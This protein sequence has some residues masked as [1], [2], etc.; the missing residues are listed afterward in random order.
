[1]CSHYETRSASSRALA[2]AIVTASLVLSMALVLAACGEISF[3]AGQHL[4]RGAAFEAQGDFGAASIE[5]RN[6]LQQDPGNAEAR[7][8]LGMLLLGIRDGSGAEAEL[9]RAQD[10]GWDPGELILPLA[11][12]MWLQGEHEDVLAATQQTDALPDALVPESLALRGLAKLISGDTAGAREDFEQA[13]AIA[14]RQ[15]DALMGMA[16]LEASQGEIQR[17]REWL[18]ELLAADPGAD[19]AWEFLGD[20]EEHAGDAE[21]ALAA[22]DRAVEL[23]PQPLSPLLK[24][25]L[26]RV[27]LQDL[28]GA[29]ADAATLERR[30]DA[31]PGASYAQ[32][33]IKFHEQSYAEA[34]TFFEESLVRHTDYPPALL[35]LGSTHLQL[36]NAQQAEQLLRRY[37][38]LVPDSVPAIEQLVRLHA[39]RTEPNEARRLLRDLTGGSNGAHPRLKALES[40]LALASGD[41]EQGLALLN[42]LAAA[43]PDAAQWHELRGMEL[44]RQGDRDGGMTALRQ[45]AAVDEQARRAD[46]IIIM[47]ELDAGNYESA[48]A[49]ARSLQEK[50]PDR[51]EPWN[52]IG[53]AL[54]GLGR[55]EDAREA[56]RQGVAVE[57]SHVATGMNLGNLELVLGNPVGADEAFRT[58]QHHHPGHAPSAQ[59]LA[60]LALQAQ[61]FDAAILW[62]REATQAQPEAIVP[63]LL[64]A[65]IQVHQ[66]Q[67]AEAAQTLEQ[68][69]EHH[70][71]DRDVPYALSEVY[72]EAGRVEDALRVLEHALADAPDDLDFTLA[73]AQVQLRAGNLTAHEQALRKALAL[74]PQHF[75]ARVALARTLTQREAWGELEPHLRELRDQHAD[76]AEVQA[77]IGQAALAQGDAVEAATAYARAVAAHPGE[78]SWVVGLATAQWQANAREQSQTTLRGWLEANPDDLATW[79]MLAG[80]QLGLDQSE[81]ALASYQQILARNPDDPIALN[82]AAWLVRD[83]DPLKALEYAERAH[84][85]APERPRVVHT[86]GVVLLA[87]GDLARALEVL[88]QAVERDPNAPDFQYNLA[89]AQA[90]AG[91]RADAAVTLTQ[92]LDRHDTFPEREAAESLLHS[93]NAE[94]LD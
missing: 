84:E 48:L 65:R 15:A 83:Q 37:L 21:G 44:I 60:E 16:R 79:H 61:D 30:F 28:D 5:Y 42:S 58:I 34:R 52:F 23:S 72:A 39:E 92:L 82:N 74:E 89:R 57:P 88:E 13:L 36:G 46:I 66:G 90:E 2:S 8:R 80:R 4:E 54:M 14:P 45:A 51:A 67:L 20:L 17:A 55:A 7:F 41:D 87:Q 24:R 70:P 50:E 62:L 6:A 27:S 38:N 19:Q 86:L 18:A 9:R 56:F 68:A 10:L 75:G 31:H 3:T 12:A 29:R 32:G 85:L 94:R 43:E 63:H 11:R 76:R 93:L 33:L 73:L 59:R 40:Q 81:A 71:T 25:T 53:G 78:R 49:A 26:L 69:R 22:Y 77:L 47:S 1:M 91:H 35:M 64:M